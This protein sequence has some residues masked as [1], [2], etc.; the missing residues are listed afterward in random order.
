M[1]RMFGKMTNP[2][3]DTV[4]TLL[5]D[6]AHLVRL[7]LDRALKPFNLTRTTW[8]AIGTIAR[9]ESLSQADLARELELGAATTGALVDRLEQRDLVLRHS[10]PGDR[11]LNLLTLTDKA[12]KQLRT[13]ETLDAEI[14]EDVLRDLDC[15]ERQQLAELLGRIK[16]SM[17]EQ[18]EERKNRNTGG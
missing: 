10:D 18:T 9:H 4:G 7:R 3:N 1:H 12:R 13:L 14:R 16:T 8:L 5:H 15:R 11:R 6:T 2:Q 17:M